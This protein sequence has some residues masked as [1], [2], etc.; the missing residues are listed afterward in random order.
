M[1]ANHAN[2]SLMKAATYTEYGPPE[3]LKLADVEKPSPEDNEVLIRI[4][5]TSVTSGDVNG[6]NFVFVPPGFNLLA[7]LMMGVREPKNKI[8]GIELAG[9]VVATGKDV[10][11]FSVGDQVFGMDGEKMGAYAEFKTLAEDGPLALMPDN[12]SSEE[13]A[14]IPFGATTAY[15]FLQDKGQI[16]RGQKVLI[17]GA[18]GGVGVY[19]VQLAS[20]FGGQVTGV[21]STANLDLVK[22]LG[23]SKVIDYTQEDF[24][25]NGETYDLIFD[26]VV[27]QTSYSRIKRS[28]KPDGVYLAVAGGMREMLQTMSTS[29]FGGQKVSGGAAAE[30]QEDLFFLKELIESGDLKPVIDR[31]YSLDDI[32]EAHRYVDTGRKK[33]AVVVT[34][35]KEDGSP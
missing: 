20:H 30:R 22:D 26:T 7:R 35:I 9:E 31:C 29:M 34:V 5:A 3:V 21:C 28:L 16:K 23:A 24:T 2:Q 8:L 25:Q 10:T 4:R 15:Y 19:A 14:S 18:S 6:R 13:A 32:V 12:I 33:G 1:A 17:N 11:R 27:G